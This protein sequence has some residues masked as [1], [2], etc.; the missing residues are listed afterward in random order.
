MKD[1]S[2]RFETIEGH[3]EPFDT[4]DLSRS[5][6]IGMHFGTKA[7]ALNF[8]DYPY[9]VFLNITTPLEIICSKWYYSVVT[10]RRWY[11]THIQRKKRTVDRSKKAWRDRNKH[12]TLVEHQHTVSDDNLAFV[13]R[14]RKL[15]ADPVSWQTTDFKRWEMG[16][17]QSAGGEG[18]RQDA[19]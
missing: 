12:C 6:D 2:W 5:R 8:G 13:S 3:Q 19:R 10:W 14:N 7:Q 11:D 17:N 16:G 4:F 9:E 18:T 1:N 15:F